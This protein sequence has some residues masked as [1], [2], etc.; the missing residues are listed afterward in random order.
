M[1]GLCSRRIV[2]TASSTDATSMSRQNFARSGLNT[3]DRVL[4]AFGALAPTVLGVVS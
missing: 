1:L 4:V 2:K 3:N